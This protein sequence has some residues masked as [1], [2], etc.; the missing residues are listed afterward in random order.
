MF[1]IPMYMYVAT[2]IRCLLT[3]CVHGGMMCVHPQNTAN[4][5]HRQHISYRV[6]QIHTERLNP[7]TVKSTT[8]ASEMR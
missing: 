8:T 3:M 7:Y 5:T 4:H 2:N 6:C 1:L